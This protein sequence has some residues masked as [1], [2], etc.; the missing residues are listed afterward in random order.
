MLSVSGFILAGG[1]SSRMGTDKA[2]LRFEGQTLLES[3]LRRMRAVADPVWVVASRPDLGT[4]APIIPDIY[5][6]CGPLGGIHAALLAS[7]ADLNLV[8]A[9]DMPF[10]PVEV[11][12]SLI[13]IAAESQASVVVPETP[14]GRQPLCAVYRRE[15]R[16]LAEAALKSGNYKID[17]LF[18]QTGTRTVQQGEIE[19][20]GFGAEIFANLNS[21]EDLRKSR[22]APRIEIAD[23]H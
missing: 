7:R 15:F 19:S 16:E 18:A 6:H 11:L 9:V 20:W 14:D 5:A 22:P 3:A 4:Y 17:R 13:T 2:L 1:K 23:E 10:V 21:P 12:R 8:L